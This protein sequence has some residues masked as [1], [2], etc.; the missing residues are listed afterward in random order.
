MITNASSFYTDIGRGYPAQANAAQNAKNA[1]TST[2]QISA[3]NKTSDQQQAEVQALKTRDQEVR[4]HEQAHI[5][6][7][8]GIAL[9][10]AHFTYTTGP[11]GN[12]YAT[13]GDV[14]IDISTVPGDPEATLRKAETIRR[15]AMAPAS[16]SS[17]DYS[18]AAKAAQMANA[19]RIE[20]FRMQQETQ[21]SGSQLDIRI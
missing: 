20:L 18:V 21:S 14:S 7:A 9:G 10:G 8:G 17:Q 19:A 1:L 11:D 6:A 3:S 15:A 13:G 5:S 4:N 12:R 16:P 2:G